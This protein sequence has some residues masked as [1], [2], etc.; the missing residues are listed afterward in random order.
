MPYI[1]N[2]R[3][4]LLEPITAAAAENSGELNY[5]ITRLCIEYLMNH[6]K[7]YS[8][9]NDIVGALVCA[10]DEFTRRI[11]IPHEVE[12]IEKNGDVY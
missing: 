10:K 4:D 1:E 12:A 3:R 9:M 2:S 8:T 6:P 11:I 5:Q 7:K